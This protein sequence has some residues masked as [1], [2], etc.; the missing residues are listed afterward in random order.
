MAF[1][2]KEKNNTQLIEKTMNV[3]VIRKDGK[4]LGSFKKNNNQFGS[5][6][7]EQILK[8][9]NLTFALIAG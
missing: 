8:E 4:V 6:T 1:I 9:A 7:R 3:F 5:K 2:L